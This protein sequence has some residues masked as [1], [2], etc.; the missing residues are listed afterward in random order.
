MMSETVELEVRGDEESLA[1]LE[2]ALKA[3]GTEPEVGEVN[4]LDGGPDFW[5]LVAKIAATAVNAVTPLVLGLIRSSKIK[6]V[7]VNGMELQGISE[8]DAERLLKTAGKPK[9]AGG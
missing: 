1:D 2:A 4:G 3:H 7:K 9:P 6:S 5:L 8:A